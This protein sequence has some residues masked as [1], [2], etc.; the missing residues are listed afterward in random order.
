MVNGTLYGSYAGDNFCYIYAGFEVILSVTKILVDIFV[1][2]TQ[3][4]GSIAIMQL[5]VS[6]AF[7][8]V[9]VSAANM[10][11][12]IFIVIMQMGVTATIMQVLF[13]AVDYVYDCFNCNYAGVFSQLCR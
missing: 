10:W 5:E 3:V 4:N 2:I 9:T 11:V 12:K 8:Q 7:L 6:A 1:A 13:S